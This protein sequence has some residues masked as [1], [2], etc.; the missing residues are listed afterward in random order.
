MG[1]WMPLRLQSSVPGSFQVALVSLK[2]SL[3]TA[4]DGFRLGMIFTLSS[5]TVNDALLTPRYDRRAGSTIFGWH[6]GAGGWQR[7]DYLRTA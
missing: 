3:R 1:C 6:E 7:E 4:S 2:P 5:P